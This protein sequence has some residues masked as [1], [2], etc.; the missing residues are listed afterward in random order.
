MSTIDS[1][2]VRRR[3]RR[4]K[5]GLFVSDAETVWAGHITRRVVGGKEIESVLR[6]KLFDG[7]LMDEDP[8]RDQ[9]GEVDRVARTATEREGVAVNDS[10]GRGLRE[11]VTSSESDA[12]LE[13]YTVGIDLESVGIGR[14][15]TRNRPPGGQ[16]I[17]VERVECRGKGEEDRRKK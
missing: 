14:V 15:R 10:L 16:R 9:D 8:S 1:V 13:A 5:I 2:A 17:E 6:L 3:P 11:A 12:V 7:D 4:V